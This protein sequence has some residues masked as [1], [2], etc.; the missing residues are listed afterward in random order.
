VR[1]R[2][3]PVQLD[4]FALDAAFEKDQARLEYAVLKQTDGGATFAARLPAASPG[5]LRSEVERIV[6]SLSIT[7]PIK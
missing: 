1:V 2:S 6:R 5:I 4:R 7:R 3:E